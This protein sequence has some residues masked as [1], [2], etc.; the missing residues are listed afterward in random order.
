[1]RSLSLSG[2]DNLKYICFNMIKIDN[3]SNSIFHSH[4]HE[5]ANKKNKDLTLFAIKPIKKIIF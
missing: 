5:E 2:L 1:M 3:L 4:L